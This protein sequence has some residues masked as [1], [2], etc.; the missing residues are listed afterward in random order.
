LLLQLS[1]CQISH[2]GHTNLTKTM[3]GWPYPIAGLFAELRKKAEQL[4]E[5]ERWYDIHG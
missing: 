1:G 2:A 3:P 5:I 4:T